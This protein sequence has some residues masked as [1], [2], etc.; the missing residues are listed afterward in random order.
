MTKREFIRLLI[1]APD[2]A[3]ICLVAPDGKINDI[4]TIRQAHPRPG[5]LKNDEVYL[6]PTKGRI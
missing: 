1:D 4:D 3:D 2:E 6:Y 5:F